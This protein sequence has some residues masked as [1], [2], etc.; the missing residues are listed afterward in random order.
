[1]WINLFVGGKKLHM[2]VLLAGVFVFTVTLALVGLIGAMYPADNWPW[3][4]A[5]VIAVAMLGSM[6]ASLFIF[7]MPG[8]R[9]TMPGKTI[10]ELIGE[11]Q[12]QGMLISE[13]FSAVRAFQV[14]EFEDE[15]SHY[16]IELTDGAVF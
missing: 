12:E 16:F 4:A 5:P 1:M 6:I 10:E 14:E 2:R 9:P 11:L 15:G 3:W 7:N 13:S 8:Y